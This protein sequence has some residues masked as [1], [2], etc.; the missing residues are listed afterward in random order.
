MNVSQYVPKGNSMK[1]GTNL[2]SLCKKKGLTLTQLARNASIPIQT[3][4]GWTSG[5][6]AVKLEQL[7]ESR[8]RSRNFSS[9]TCFWF[10]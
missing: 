5:R 6:S 4:H 3:L 7:E 9:R 2:S 10:A 1:L 8:R